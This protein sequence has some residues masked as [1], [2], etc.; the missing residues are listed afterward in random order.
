[1][2]TQDDLI[3]RPIKF[4]ELSQLNK[5]SALEFK[6]DLQRQF[7]FFLEH[8]FFH[9]IIAEVDGKIVGCANVLQNKTS[10]WLGSAIVL[11]E[12]RGQGIGY[13]LVQF[14]INLLK[15]KGC[16]TFLCMTSKLGGRVVKKFRF[17]QKSNYIFFNR[18]K[19]LDFL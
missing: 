3:I 9:P 16:D 1:M 6:S 15:S 10:A 13:A 17:L 2:S 19:P 11:P 5:L 7:N 12:Y 14:R 4:S 8:S 18:K